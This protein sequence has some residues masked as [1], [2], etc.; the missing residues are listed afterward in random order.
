M[1]KKILW[2]T[3]SCVMALSLVLASCAPAATEE[4]EVVE[5]KEAKVATEEAKEVTAPAPVEEEKKPVSITIARKDG[6]TTVVEKEQPEYGGWANVFITSGSSFDPVVFNQ[7]W[8]PKMQ[9]EQLLDENHLWGPSG[10]GEL[11]RVTSYCP[12][13]DGYWGCLAESYEVIGPLTWRFHLREGVYFLDKPPANGREMTADDWVYTIEV[14]QSNPQSIDY[15]APGK[16][17]IEAV[18][19]DKY[20]LDVTVLLLGDAS[21]LTLVDHFVV[22][23]REIEGVD[24]EDWRNQTGTGPFYVTDYVP[25]TLVEMSKNPNY[26]RTDPF[27]PENK[28]PYIDGVRQLIIPDLGTQFAALRT[29]KIDKMRAIY[30]EDAMSLMNTNPELKYKQDLDHRT[31]HIQPRNDK[32]PFSDVR[33]RQ[34]MAM[35]IDFDEI[36]QDYYGGEAELFYNPARPEFTN[37]FTPLEEMPPEVQALYSHDV[38]GAKALL[39][40]T[41]Y[42]TGFDFECLVQAKDLERLEV[43]QAYLADIGVNMEINLMESGAFGSLYW[44]SKFEEAVFRPWGNVDPLVGIGRLWVTDARYN[45]TRSSDPHVDAE[46]DAISKLVG[47]EHKA[48][49]NKRLKELCQYIVEQQFIISFPASKQA[50]YFWQPWLKGFTGEYSYGNRHVWEGPLQY[51]WIDQDVK[52]EMVR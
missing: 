22:F 5:E 39:A 44:G 32:P 33:V 11:A 30:Q 52:T 7:Y 37:A 2:L 28:L 23:P 4:K 50:Y 36:V 8:A 42:P 48:E 47:A 43:F 10:T 40:E 9:Y 46:Y 15:L 51:V 34:A 20:T 49:Y 6:G 45:L 29:G 27:F 35:S 24:M 16:P 12:F 31:P 26:W 17:R 38:A 19:V 18:A 14:L 21:F 3:V 13:P 25:G 1:K 41:D